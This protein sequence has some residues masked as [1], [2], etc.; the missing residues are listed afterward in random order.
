MQ[1]L[2]DHTIVVAGG[3]AS[4]SSFIMRALLEREATVVVPSR[5]E[6]KLGGLREHLSRHDVDKTDLGRLHTFVGNLGDETEAT[7]LR[8]RITEEVGA[9]DARQPL[10]GSGRLFGNAPAPFHEPTRYTRPQCSH[11]PRRR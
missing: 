11:L 8:Q 9:P 6:E 10:S 2:N 7:G 4:V 3:T 1:S 5:S